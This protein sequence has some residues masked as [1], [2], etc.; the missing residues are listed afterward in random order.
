MLD[1]S[2]GGLYG[3]GSALRPSR[4]INRAEVASAVV[5]I[6]SG[7]ALLTAGVLRVGWSVA[8][9]W[10]GQ[11]FVD[12]W[13]YSRA[14]SRWLDGLSVFD[15]AQLSGP[16]Q[17]VSMTGIGYAYPPVSLPLFLPFASF[18]VGLVLWEALLIGVLLSGLFQIAGM[19]WPE[20]RPVAFGLMLL[21]LGLFP[22]VAQGLAVGN[23]TMLSVGALPWIWVGARRSEVA[24]GALTAFKVF[25]GAIS[26]LDGPRGMIRTAIVAVSLAVVTL[27]LVGLDLWRDFFLALANAQP[28][29]LGYPENVSVACTMAPHVG[30]AV[31]K[32]I[33]L[34]MAVAATVVALLAKTTVIRVIAVSAAVMAPA[35][36]LHLFYWSFLPVVA[37]I[38]VADLAAKRRTKTFRS[39]D[40]MS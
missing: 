11:W 30:V 29:C 28:R 7:T 5:L 24:L 39:A 9:Y 20:R 31:A 40:W 3:P 13:T 18:P 38:A 4:P 25:P 10:R 17:L 8:D 35:A 16:Y 15:P 22:P 36:D 33:G 23:A 6:A 34:G 32:A 12:W 14:V 19:G 37:F 26:A 2:R 27:P 21:L 1:R